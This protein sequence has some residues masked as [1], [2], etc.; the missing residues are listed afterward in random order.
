MSGLIDSID[1]RNI[2]I[3][4]GLLCAKQPKIRAEALTLRAE[5]STLGGR[6]WTVTSQ[7]SSQYVVGRK[8]IRGTVEREQYASLEENALNRASPLSP[9]SSSKEGGAACNLPARLK[10]IDMER[11]LIGA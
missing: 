6:R 1:M 2:G 9:P 4:L 8:T 3:R 11:A 5:F 10:A 7:T